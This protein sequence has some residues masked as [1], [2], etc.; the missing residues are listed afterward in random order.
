MEKRQKVNEN[1]CGSPERDAFMFKRKDSLV[2]LDIGSHSIKMVQLEAKASSL[3]LQ[4]LGLI[5]LPRDAFAEGRVSKAELV[6]KTIQQLIAHLK[7]KEKLVATSISGY[8][9]MIKKIELPVMSEHE[10]SARMQSELGQYIPFNIEEVHVD[11][12]VL[13]MVKDRPNQMEVLLVAAKKESIN[14]HV[15]LLRLSGVD[16]MVI[17]VD[18][19]AL[20][21]VY[22]ANFGRSEEC[23]AL[24]DIGANKTLVDI[25]HRGVPI[26]TRGISIGGY[27]I[28]ESIRDA[29]RVS[30]E[31][32]ERIK[33][34]EASEHVSQQ[35]VANVFVSIVRDWVREF[36]RAFD[37]Y[38]SNFPDNKIDKLFLSGGSCRIPGLDKVLQENLAAEVGIFNPFS[39]VEKDPK[40]FDPGYLDYIGPQMAISLGL[41]LRKAKSK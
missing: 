20:S 34:G 24:M 26:F 31:E 9:V 21:N 37:F 39:Q 18:F 3:R 41:A 40:V 2:G 17:D 10:L 4:S 7:L 11:Y 12:Q 29:F 22:E 35:E 13:D 23:I 6:A 25:V 28:T 32:A 30:E 16:P 8:E 5:P 27:Q 38:Y 36:R 14:D 33:L 19:F 15:N 1:L